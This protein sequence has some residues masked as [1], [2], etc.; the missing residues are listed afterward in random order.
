M[1]PNRPKDV[2]RV[3]SANYVAYELAKKFMEEELQVTRS[4]IPVKVL[5]VKKRTNALMLRPKVPH[6]IGKIG[7]GSDFLSEK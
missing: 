6:S 5:K 2:S 7:E 1:F 3:V 4:L